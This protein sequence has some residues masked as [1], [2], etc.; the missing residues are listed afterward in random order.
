MLM[1][2][3]TMPTIY[4]KIFQNVHIFWRKIQNR[5]KKSYY[6][7][8]PLMAKYKISKISI[9]FILSSF[10]FLIWFNL[11]CQVP[12][13]DVGQGEH[14]ILTKIYIDGDTWWWPGSETILLSWLN[15]NGKYMY[16][17]MFGLFVLGMSNKL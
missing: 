9:I 14:K 12:G 5:S 1:G 3:E 7:F 16:V 8:K 17:C 6:K 4:G 2:K 11:S 15:A 13:Q 10:D